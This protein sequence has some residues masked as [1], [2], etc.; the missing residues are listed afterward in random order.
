M[1]RLVICFHDHRRATYLR[2]LVRRDFMTCESGGVKVD[3]ACSG[4]SSGPIVTSRGVEG[5][6]LTKQA[7]KYWA[8]CGTAWPC[9]EMARSVNVCGQAFDLL[10]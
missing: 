3:H 6:Q 5:A 8:A 2:A 1:A 4:P 10:E 7:G 9:L